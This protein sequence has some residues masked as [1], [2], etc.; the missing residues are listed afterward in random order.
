MVMVS[1]VVMPTLGWR[2]LLVFATIPVV[3]FLILCKVIVNMLLDSPLTLQS[4]KRV[5]TTHDP[6][7]LARYKARKRS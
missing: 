2:W 6:F 7:I 4:A 3:I 1:L 5:T